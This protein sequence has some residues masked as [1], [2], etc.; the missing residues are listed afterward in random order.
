MPDASVRAIAVALLVSSPGLR[1]QAAAT[2]AAAPVATTVPVPLPVQLGAPTPDSL[3]RLVLDRFATGTADAFDSVYPDPLGRLVVRNAAQRKQRRT[4][5][6]RR[7]LWSNADHAVLLLT[8]TVLA[9][10]AAGTGIETGSDET[11]IVRRLSGLYEAART[12]G[13]WMLTRQIPFDTLNFIR[14]QTLHVAIAPGD[15]SDIVDTLAIEVGSPY[16]FSARLN[17]ATHLAKVALD[18]RPADYE[19]GGGVL[20]IRAPRRAPRPSQLVLAYSIP[21]QHEP[22]T[23]ALG[24]SAAPAP[25]GDSLPAYG[26]MN[27]TDA[28]HPFFNY[29][30]GNDFGPLTVTATIPA[31]YRLTTTVP[32]TETVHDGVRTVHGES[33]H[34]QFLLALLYDRDWRP[35]TTPIGD[36]ELRVETFFEPKFHF[37]PDTIARTVALVYRVL[38]PRFGEAQAPSRYLAVVEDRALGHGGWAVRMNNAVI[39]GD[40]ATTLDEP[41][42]GPSFA[43]AHEVAHGWTMNAS[44]LAANFLQEGWA[45]YCES[46]VLRAVYGPDVERAYWERMRTSYVTGL[47]RAGFLGGFEGRQSI[48]G[49][50]DNG[51]IH[52]SKGSWVLHELDEVMGDSA[53]DRGMRAFIEHAGHGPNGY[54]EF[55]A[56]MSRAAGHDMT[57]FIMP[58]LSGTH[59]PDVDARVEGGSLI[60]SQAQNGDV[61][62]LPL[63]IELTTA[64]GTERR[65][66]HLTT[67][68]DTIQLGTGQAVSAVRVDPDHR[69]LLR[70]H[71][72]ERVRFTLRAPQARTVELSGN[73]VAK[74]VPATRD[75]DLWT[76]DLPVPEGRYIWLWRVDGKNPS[77]DEALAAA[78]APPTGESTALA[79]IRIVRPLI[80][81]D[82][83]DAR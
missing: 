25:P 83:A 29:D 39:S 1:A 26:A 63:D 37:A 78:K 23:R 77:D 58:W 76:V 12:D 40:G 20:W 44:G 11:N 65:Q 31:A 16:G 4:A 42:L 28:W 24:D 71:W 79:G 74:P 82:D 3:S 18:G 8:G 38:E 72:G 67:R 51:R 32:Q 59:I 57:S 30:S 45:T 9:G 21:A 6:L 73:F 43:F 14:A 10:D 2:A 69:F 70:R 15:R 33:L 81:L 75:G 53:F 52:Y 27:N 55:I 7:V 17:N 54:P 46:L 35:V 47:D 66:V 13:T 80:R 61:F 34:P 60:V 5:G 68:A 36:G 62:E 49:N 22:P 48:I 19:L 41:V 50:P 64:A 56:D